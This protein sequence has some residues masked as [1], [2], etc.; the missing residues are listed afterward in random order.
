MVMPYSVGPQ[1]VA[2]PYHRLND[3]LNPA[4]LLADFWQLTSR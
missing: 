2:I 1:T 4:S 3:K